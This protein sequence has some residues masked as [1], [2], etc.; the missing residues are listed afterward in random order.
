MGIKLKQGIYIKR[1]GNSTPSPTWKFGFT[2]EGPITTSLS[3]RKLGA[4]LRQIHPLLHNMS[5][6][7]PRLR[8]HHHHHQKEKGFEHPNNQ[9]TDPPHSPT[10]QPASASSLRRYI[11]A[12]LIQHHNSVDRNGHAHAL[13]PVSPAS[14]ASSSLEVAP[15]NPTVTPASSVDFKGRIGEGNYSLK[16]STELLKVLNRI[17]TLEEQHASN[18]SLVK[19]LKAELDHSRA[20]IKEL[21]QEKKRDRQEMNNLMKNKDHERI[22]ETVQSMRKELEDE[23][24][25]RKHSESIHR[26]LARELSDVKSSFSNALKELERERKARILLENLCDEFAKG[27]RDYEQE[28]RMMKQKPDKER[29]IKEQPERLILHISEAWLD[30]RMQMKLADGRSDPNEKNTIVDKLSSEIETF[31]QAKQSKR[32]SVESFHLNKAASAPQNADYDE[33]SCGSASHCFELNRGSSGKHRNMSKQGEN[34]QEIVK[35]N[36]MKKKIQSRE[37]FDGHDLPLQTQYQERISGAVTGNISKNHLGQEN[38]VELKTLQNPEM[39]EFTQEG[40][41]ERR[42]NST[43]LT[44]NHSCSYERPGFTGDDHTIEQWRSKLNTADPEPPETSSKWPRGLKEN[45]LKAKLLEARLEGRHS[46]S[47]TSKG[48]FS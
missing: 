2:P 10:E 36:P 19:A 45:T 6:G 13:Q 17:W 39:S 15:Y 48:S 42:G 38:P 22:K 14:Y 12:S 41:R 5:H 23:R 9:L 3:A 20:Q 44:R 35:M 7:G 31:L 29:V 34:G 27:I 25:L 21:L 30:E 40:S 8:H 28:V 4:K 16:T 33:D 47:R 18:S 43:N 1:G 24:K 46:R 37:V 11:E 26:K 32:H